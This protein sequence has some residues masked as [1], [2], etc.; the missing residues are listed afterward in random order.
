MYVSWC[1]CGDQKELGK[2]SSVLILV[3]GIR[4]GLAGKTAGSP[5]SSAVS[6]AQVLTFWVS[7]VYIYLFIHFVRGGLYMS[8]TVC[9]LKQRMTLGVNYLLLLVCPEN[10]TQAVLLGSG[11]ILSLPLPFFFSFLFFWDRVSNSGLPRTPYLLEGD[12][13]LWILL[14]V[15]C[16]YSTWFFDVLDVGPG[17]A[18][19]ILPLELY[20]QPSLY[21]FHLIIF[22][23]DSVSLCKFDRP[24]TCCLLC[25]PCQPLSPPLYLQPS[26]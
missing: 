16:E 1:T 14:S 13:E 6:P 5:A 19:L 3:L 10:R 21:L 18:R 23:C 4:L 9:I 15:P 17:R 8:V 22:F 25:R 7:L 20:L 24:R 11:T 2:S 12:T 26:A